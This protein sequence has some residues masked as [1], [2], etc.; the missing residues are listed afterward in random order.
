VRDGI[1]LAREGLPAV[2]LVTEPFWE[3]GCAV[4]EGAGMPDVPRLMLPYPIAGQPQAR[5][6]EIA[7]D[8]ASA[9]LELLRGS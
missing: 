6:R 1:N 8:N 7:R 9:V 2:A 3:Q 5:L 4:A